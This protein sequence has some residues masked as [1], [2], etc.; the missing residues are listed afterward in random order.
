MD[1]VYNIDDDTKIL[2]YKLQTTQKEVKERLIKSKTD[3]VIR[4]NKNSK[5]IEYKTGQLVLVKN[6]I[7]SKFN[8]TYEGPYPVVAD[9]GP[10]VEI[11]IKDQVD[12]IHKSRTKPFITRSSS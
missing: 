9:K 2:K 1:P 7:K 12:S 8:K 3:R 4:S 5:E 11:R 6:E 10:N